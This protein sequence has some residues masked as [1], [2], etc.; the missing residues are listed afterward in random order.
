MKKVNTIIILVLFSVTFCILGMHIFDS[1][2]SMLPA[3]NQKTSGEHGVYQPLAHINLGNVEVYNYQRMGFT[4]GFLKFSPDNNYL[5][6][7][8]EN[9]E[10]LMITMQGTV[11][12]QKNVGIGK[13]TALQFSKDGKQLLIGDT[14][15]QGALLCWNTIDGTEIWRRNSV[16]ELGVDIKDKTYPGIAYIT[17]DEQGN[18]YAVASRSIR[19]ADNSSEYRGRIYKFDQRGKALGL[20][21]A[22]HNIDASVC[23]LTV[24]QAG[25]KVVF[26]TANWDLT[27]IKEYA[28]SIYCLDGALQG[29]MWSTLLEPIPPYR[30]TT[31]RASPDM[32]ENGQYIGS[33]VSDGRAFLHDGTGKKLWEYSIS[34]PQKIGG[35]YINATGS[36]VQ[37][38][39][40]CVVVTTGNTYNRANWQLPTPVEHPSS[41]SMFVFDVSGKL[42]HKQ[43]L[44]GMIEQM[45][46]NDKQVV[47]AIGRNVRT[48]EVGVHG[49]SI[50]SLPKGEIMDTVHTVGP[51]VGA[52]ISPS[53]EYIAGVEAPL[54]LDD[55][56]VIGD[57]KLLLLKKK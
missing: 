47:L 41:N 3:A 36:Y 50:L 44:G 32:S 46:V 7:G 15:P 11:L 2:G 5:A 16:Q 22:D 9:G 12:W 54:Q 38:I 37:V 30:N 35:V 45:A 19:N 17:T 31:M 20:F 27:S 43:K 25:E 24:D 40:N 48:K 26:G 8:T 13:I 21:P 4:H 56:Q 1:Q 28:E 10:I 39:G 52:A 53:G 42:I 57:Y 29:V 18:I 14:S 55:G 51:C 33:M 6:V 34:Q 49:L 23:W